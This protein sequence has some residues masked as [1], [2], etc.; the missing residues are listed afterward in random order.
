MGKKIKEL[1]IL[2]KNCTIITM[3]P[4]RAIIHDGLVG[5]RDSRIEF[6]GSAETIETQKKWD[7]HNIELHAERVI[8]GNGGVLLPGLI[9]THAHAGHGLT[10]T[11]GEGGV[12][13]EKDWNVLME[14]IYF[15]ASTPEFWRAEALLTG[16]ERLK[17]GVTT[18]MNMFGSYPR[19]DGAENWEAHVEG[20]STIGVRDI[21]GIGTPNPPFPKTFRKW[22]GERSDSSFDQYSL[23]HRDSFAK[24]EEAVRRFHG[25]NDGISLCYPTPSGV[26]YREGLSLEEHIAQ[27][28]AMKDISEKYGVPLHS[29]SYSGDISYAREHFPFILGPHLSLAHCTGISEEEIQIL[30]ETGTS[31]CSGPSTGSYIKARCPVVELMEAGCNVTFCTDA[32]APDRTYDLFEKMRF[33]VRL[34]RVHFH[35][36]GVLPAGKALEMVTIDAAQALGLSDSLGSIEA[37]KKADVILVDMNKPHLYPVWQEPLRMVY[38]ASGQDVDTAIVNGKVLMH[39]RR[40]S[41]IDEKGILEDAQEQAQLALKRMGFEKSADLPDKLWGAV[42]Y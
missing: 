20:M 29:H 2:L 36:M 9:D 32:S 30:S 39:R 16:L 24:T 41:G 40:V 10:K 6:V 25:L 34:H 28:R 14:K 13:E 12:G 5:I 38:Q 8:D 42:H 18:G 15:Q 27:N 37:G 23:S 35:D 33:G 21:L 7:I 4:E 19:Y 31:V 3:N 17:F 26:G 22:H 1:S 11:L